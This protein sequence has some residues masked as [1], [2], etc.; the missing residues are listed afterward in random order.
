MAVMYQ[1]AN[2]SIFGPVVFNAALDDGNTMLLAK[3]ATS[4]QA[5]R[6]AAKPRCLPKPGKT[7]PAP[8]LLRTACG[9]FRVA[10]Q[11]PSRKGGRVYVSRK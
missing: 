3:V 4:A 6:L 8:A 11:L 9:L 1:E 5:E 7:R 2:R 10:A